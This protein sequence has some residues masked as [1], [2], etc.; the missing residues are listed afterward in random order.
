M[1]SILLI[2]M[3]GAFVVSSAQVTGGSGSILVQ[4]KPIKSGDKLKLARKRFYLF[5]GGFKENAALLERIKKEEMP[6]RDCYYTQAKASPA[7]M[8]WL[9]AENCD[10]PFCRPVLQAEIVGVPE[11]D[12][13]YK[14]GLTLY[15]SKPA[16]ALSWLINNL[17]APLVAGYYDQQRAYIDRVLGTLKPLQTTQATIT[18]AEAYFVDLPVS[19]KGQKYL[20]STIIPVELGDKS[21]VWTCEVTDLGPNKFL[22]KVPLPLK[23]NAKCQVTEVKQQICKTGACPAK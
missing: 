19:D 22:S 20:V 10:G 16:L 21:F 7:F 18:A 2:L 8:C 9:Q 23:T 5:N 11:F 14:K 4:A 3:L 13:A 17:D 1:R 6:S 15:K 12:A